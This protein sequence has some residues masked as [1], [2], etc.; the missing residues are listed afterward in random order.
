MF[1]FFGFALVLGLFYLYPRLYE[2]KGLLQ[3][4]IIEMFNNK[5][6]KK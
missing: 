4:D 6:N 3:K 5:Q 1:F 2:T